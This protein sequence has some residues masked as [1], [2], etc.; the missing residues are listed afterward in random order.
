MS[1]FLTT[2]NFKVKSVNC[3]VLYNPNNGEI[4]HVHRIV[5]MENAYEASTKEL[6]QRTLEMAG[7][8]GTDISSMKLLHVDEKMIES[9][10]KYKVDVNNQRLEEIK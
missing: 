5:T 4:C 7:E 9:G 6:E 1:N 8:L 3:C 2:G 10:K